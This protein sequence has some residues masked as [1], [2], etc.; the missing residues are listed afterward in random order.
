[1]HLKNNNIRHIGAKTFS[2]LQNLAELYLD[3]NS[4]GNLNDNQFLNTPK[5]RVISLVRCKLTSI[6]ELP[7]FIKSIHLGG[8]PIQSLLS[9]DFS[10]LRNLVDPDLCNQYMKAQADYS[11]IDEDFYVDYNYEYDYYYDSNYDNCDYGRS[12]INASDYPLS[13][14][15]KGAYNSLDHLSAI[16]LRGN[17]I[18]YVSP[19]AFVNLP[20]LIDLDLSYNEIAYLL[21]DTFVNVPRLRFLY[22]HGNKL[23]ALPPELFGTL[24]ALDKVTLYNN[25][26]RCDCW[27]HGLVQWM[28]TTDVIY[29]GRSAVKCTTS[30]SPSLL[31]VSLSQVDPQSLICEQTTTPH[32]TATSDSITKSEEDTIP[33]PT[34]NTVVTFTPRLFPPIAVALVITTATESIVQWESPSKDVMGYVISY[35]NTKGG[36]IQRTDLIR[37]NVT[38]YKISNLSPGTVYHVCIEAHYP[39]GRSAATNA[40]CVT[41]TTKEGAGADQTLVIGLAAAGVIAAVVIVGTIVMCKLRR[42]RQPTPSSTNH[43][44][45][46]IQMTASVPPP[47]NAGAAAAPTDNTLDMAAGGPTATTSDDH[48]YM[49]LVHPKPQGGRA[50]NPAATSTTGDSELGMA[51]GGPTPAPTTPVPTTPEDHFYMHLAHPPGGGATSPAATTGEYGTAPP[52]NELMNTAAGGPTPATP[53]DNFYMPLVLPDTEGG[54]RGVTNPAASP[55]RQSEVVYEDVD[56]ARQQRGGSFEDHVYQNCTL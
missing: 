13:T 38:L 29:E 51:A 36:R 48:F 56:E 24:P 26:W 40:T 14:V 52:E 50:T 18:V 53:D 5:L 15:G 45:Q 25:P 12:H 16:T 33:S 21:P 35:V 47:T 11:Q 9:G 8:N 19:G 7:P 55:D 20:S 32:I 27:L 39:V 1:M 30:L 6:P 4:L 28:N 42:M 43:T 10:D 37:P 22:L 31:N 49:H 2:D 3:G 23:T 41:A 44:A 17:G 54:A 46:S 34:R